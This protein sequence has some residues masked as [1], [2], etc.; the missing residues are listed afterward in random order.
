MQATHQILGAGLMRRARVA[1]CGAGWW[2]QGWHIPHLH[3][4]PRAEL[5]A[6]VEPEAAPRSSTGDVLAGAPAL[7]AQYGCA[8]F[9]SLDALLKSPVEVDGVLVATPH[10]TH[11]ALATAALDAGLHVLVEKPMTTDVAEARALRDAADAARARDSARGAPPRCVL[12]NNTANFRSQAVAAREMVV[13]RAAVGA[14]EHVSCVMHSPLLWLFDDAK[15]AGWVEPSGAMLGNGF[16]W[17]QLSHPLA[18]IFQV[19]A[20]EPADV[21]AAMRLSKASGADLCDAAVV[22]CVGG[23]AIAVSGSASVPGDAH[24]AAPVGKRVDFTIFGDE[25]ALTYGG[26]DQ[27]P[28]SGRL[29]LRL[30]DGAREVVDGFR[31]ENYEPEGA[32]PESLDHFIR[33]CLGEPFYEGAGAEVG[34]QAVRTLDAMYRSARSG[35]PEPAL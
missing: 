20:L 15:N 11:A 27:D 2:S 5:V 17:G 10:A 34:L 33:G 8:A 19:A 6:I 21:F 25:G 28:A 16:A 29:E 1:V 22:R 9:E 18:W 31:F 23:A 35:L 30:R 3:R 26:D 13:G 24:G 12:V 14:V 4:H 7:A 32:G